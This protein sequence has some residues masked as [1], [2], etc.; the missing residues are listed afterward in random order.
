[1]CLFHNTELP[2]L[3][4]GNKT[5]ERLKQSNNRDRPPLFLSDT[6]HCAWHWQQH[7]LLLLPNLS[8]YRTSSSDHSTA[9]LVL[10]EV[11]QLGASLRFSVC[12]H[13]KTFIQLL[14][15]SREIPVRP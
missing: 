12:S 2:G 10:A 13:E 9:R 3:G 5:S 7:H 4:W 8:H 15:K 6:V 11:P 14:T 1:M